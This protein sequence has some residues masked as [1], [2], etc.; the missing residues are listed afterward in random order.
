MM[1]ANNEWERSMKK[2]VAAA[3]LCST[4]AIQASAPGQQPLCSVPSWNEIQGIR[5]CRHDCLILRDGTTLHGHVDRLPALH[6]PFGN[7]HFTPDEIAMVIMPQSGGATIQY[8]TVDGRTYLAEKQGGTV[9]FG[10][11]EIAADRIRA[12]VLKNNGDGMHCRGNYYAL[13]MANGHQLMVELLSPFVVV[14]DGWREQMVDSASIVTFSQDGALYVRKNGKTERLDACFVRDHDVEVLVP[15]SGQTLRLPW[16]QIARLEKEGCGQIQ[17]YAMRE[18]YA[19]LG[20]FVKKEFSPGVATSGSGADHFKRLSPLF[21]AGLGKKNPSLEGAFAATVISQ[22]T[23]ESMDQHE[24]TLIVDGLMI[25][26]WMAMVPQ[27]S[28]TFADG[29]LPGAAAGMET[30]NHASMFAIGA[31]I[32]EPSLDGALAAAIITEME[33]P[34][35]GLFSL[36]TETFPGAVA[37]SPTKRHTSAYAAGAAIVEPLLDGAIAAAVVPES[38]IEQVNQLENTLIVDSI[39]IDSWMH[40]ITQK[41]REVLA[42]FGRADNEIYY[43]SLTPGVMVAHSDTFEEIGSISLDGACAAAVISQKAIDTM[44]EAE[45]A[46]AVESL[47]IDSWMM[48][49]AESRQE[50][51]VLAKLER[52]TPQM[53]AS[54]GE[55]LASED[56][57]SVETAGEDFI[58]DG[59]DDV[60]ETDEEDSDDYTFSA[61][62]PKKKGDDDEHFEPIRVF[63]LRPTVVK[64]V[65]ESFVNEDRERSKEMEQEKEQVA[66]DLAVMLDAMDMMENAGELMSADHVSLNLKKITDIAE[67]LA[68]NG[69]LYFEMEALVSEDSYDALSHERIADVRHSFEWEKKLGYLETIIRDLITE[70]CSAEPEEID[71]PIALNEFNVSKEAIEVLAQLLAED[72][73]ETV[74]AYRGEERFE[75]QDAAQS[76]LTYQDAE[77]ALVAEEYLPHFPGKIYSQEGI[78]SQEITGTLLPTSATPVVLVKVPSYYIDKREVTNKQYA[79]FVRDTGHAAPPHWKDGQ[80]PENQE[81]NP[82]VNV[83]YNDA[84]AYAAWAGKRL[85]TK[86]EWVRAADAM[87]IDEDGTIN[88]WVLMDDDGVLSFDERLRLSG[89]RDYHN[90]DT[91]FRCAQSVEN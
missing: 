29:A 62:A 71:D 50:D 14:G 68:L 28:I 59:S 7:L 1:Q 18:T 24:H 85:P 63:A 73:E 79:R 70:A 25:E 51:M 9:R 49:L 40:V 21:A 41:D 2:W 77:M 19:A 67:S 13:Q 90:R 69:E 12:L 5:N 87:L 72:D 10:S 60:V 20:D 39:M 82:V 61:A 42:S 23:I 74:I 88:E 46:L 43:A 47:M 64:E 32:S 44:G 15:K 52:M 37:S 54:L 78:D 26:S 48:L 16:N 81:D 91:G 57:G 36:G 83:S 11:E 75:T 33:H 4:V 3:C 55:A 34:A 22:Q 66:V 89:D 6:Y 8:I 45:G 84:L 31:H 30:N 86:D 38:R 17:E 65:H 35:G 80:I 76:G 27:A 56:V 58:F 53:I